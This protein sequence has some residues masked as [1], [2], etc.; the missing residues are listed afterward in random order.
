MTDRIIA[1]DDEDS[2]SEPNG[3][4]DDGIPP[5]D[6][7][8]SAGGKRTRR[9]L[10]STTGVAL[11][12]T[13]SG[14]LTNPWGPES[15]S[16]SNDDARATADDGAD[17]TNSSSDTAEADSDDAER[18]PPLEREP[19]QVVAVAPDGF[20]FDPETFEIDAGGTVHWVWKDSGHNLRVR[21]K[22]DG[23]DWE[24]TPGTASDTYD[25]GYEHAHT[26]DTPGEYHYFCAPHQ[27]LGLEGSFT[28]R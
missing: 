28:V 19:A 9:S 2:R 26:F 24:G 27:T 20:Q 11:A 12:M 7:A 22:P 17:G 14:C 5:R 25:D 3:R 18:P 6:D 16:A 23:S 1:V 8:E 4:G 13:L 10:L 15:D 21:E